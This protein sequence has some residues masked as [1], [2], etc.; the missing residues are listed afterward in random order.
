MI[1]LENL[2]EEYDWRPPIFIAQS[3]LQF[4]LAQVKLISSFCIFSNLQTVIQETI[5]SSVIVV[6]GE[7][8]AQFW[9]KR[10][11]PIEQTLRRHRF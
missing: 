5:S 4:A 1:T 9:Q 6:L 2:K 10:R 7:Q 8:V 3:Q 11:P